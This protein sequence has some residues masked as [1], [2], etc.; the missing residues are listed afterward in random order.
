MIWAILKLVSNI[1][2]LYTYLFDLHILFA[3]IAILCTTNSIN[4][5]ISF[6]VPIYIFLLIHKLYAYVLHIYILYTW[7]EYELYMFSQFKISISTS[8]LCI[9]FAIECGF[10]LFLWWYFGSALLYTLLYILLHLDIYKYINKLYE[11]KVDVGKSIF[12]HVLI[13]YKCHYIGLHRNIL[14]A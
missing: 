8:L 13:V 7:Y 6:K 2:K 4:K 11:H 5:Y 12:F 10:C 3:V 9:L 14:R 1:N